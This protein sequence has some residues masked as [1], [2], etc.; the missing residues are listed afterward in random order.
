MKKFIGYFIVFVLLSVYSSFSYGYVLVKFWD[1]YVLPTFTTLP[2]LD[3]Y[4]SIG[5]MLTITLLKGAK[6]VRTPKEEFLDKKWDTITMF[7]CLLSPW[8]VLLMGY[9]MNLIIK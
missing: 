5:L 8:I 9:I 7:T 2:K 1:W 6:M 3:L 4:H